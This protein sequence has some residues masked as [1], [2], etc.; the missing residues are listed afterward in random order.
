V[1]GRDVYVQEATYTVCVHEGARALLVQLLSFLT[2]IGGV[3]TLFI[4][5]SLLTVLEFVEWLVTM[6]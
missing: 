6:V 5:A 3:A 1:I 4:G 2:D